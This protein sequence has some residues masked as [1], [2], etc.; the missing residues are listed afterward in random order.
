MPPP[1]LLAIAEAFMAGASQSA[2]GAIPLSKEALGVLAA[3]KLSPAS[4]KDEYQSIRYIGF[5]YLTENRT[6]A[7]PRF[8]PTKSRG[9]PKSI[10]T[11]E[12]TW[13][14]TAKNEVTTRPPSPT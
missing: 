8:A 1:K 13:V 5:S 2:I 4:R 9:M 6:S 12:K 10:K 14:C 7:D 3:E 11:I